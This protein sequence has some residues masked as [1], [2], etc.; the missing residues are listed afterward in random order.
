MLA[1]S[2]MQP[3]GQAFV[4]IVGLGYWV[5]SS[6]NLR[7]VGR[8][9]SVNKC[10]FI[11]DGLWRVTIGVGLIPSA[12]G[13]TTSIFVSEPAL[14]NLEVKGRPLATLNDVKRVYG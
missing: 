2:L 8:I 12:F 6:F 1:V 7:T 9:A 13:L 11:L 5:A 14:Y 10:R 3:L 4:Q